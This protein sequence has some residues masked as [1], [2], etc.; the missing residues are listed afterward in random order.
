M[1]IGNWQYQIVVLDSY[2]MLSSGFRR[3][4]NF[5]RILHRWLGNPGHSHSA[6]FDVVTPPLSCDP[7]VICNGDLHVPCYSLELGV[8]WFGNS[9]FPWNHME[10]STEVQRS[11]MSM[12]LIVSKFHWI[13][14]NIP[15]YFTWRHQSCMQ[16]HGLYLGQTRNPDVIRNGTLLVPWNSIEL[17]H[18]LFGDSR[19]PWNSMEISMELH[20]ATMSFKM[21]RS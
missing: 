2:I 21:A 15:W 10:Y 16:F 19:I 12:E 18:I 5:H 11:L 20:G 17:V 8:I 6:L 4:V 14:W 9:I 7:G 13:S 3:T 1:K